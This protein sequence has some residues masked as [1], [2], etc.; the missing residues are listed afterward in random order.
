MALH[1]RRL[2]RLRLRLQVLLPPLLLIH[3]LDRPFLH[4]VLLLRLLRL[5]EEVLHLALILLPLLEIPPH[6]PVVVPLVNLLH[7]LDLF[8]ADH[9]P[10]VIEPS[11]ELR[12]LSVEHVSGFKN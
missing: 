12:P 9:V 7:L 5:A 2:L 6:L 3:H 10:V 4:L 11:S 1:L 8:P